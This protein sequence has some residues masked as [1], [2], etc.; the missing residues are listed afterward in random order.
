MHM[1]NTQNAQNTPRPSVED[2]VLFYANTVKDP[3]STV[4]RMHQTGTVSLDKILDSDYRDTQKT[5]PAMESKTMQHSLTIIQASIKNAAVQAGTQTLKAGLQIVTIVQEE[6]HPDL[7]LKWNDIPG[8]LHQAKVNLALHA[9]DGGLH[10]A[11]HI[12]ESSVEATKLT[13]MAMFTPPN[14]LNPVMETWL[15]DLEKH[16]TSLIQEAL[17][18]LH[19]SWKEPRDDPRATPSGTGSP[20]RHRVTNNPGPDT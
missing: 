19:Q 16:Y 14:S 9:M 10:T 4:R 15:N 11:Q 18:T 7:G 12:L 13:A 8:A 5:K 2:A 17:T 1:V 6:H 3:S 20:E